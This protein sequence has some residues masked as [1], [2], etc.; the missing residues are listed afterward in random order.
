MTAFVFCIGLMCGFLARFAVSR[1][2]YEIEPVEANH[3]NLS[4]VLIYG[5]LF[6]LL[7]L[8]L[9][10]GMLFVK[11]AV[12]TFLLG[13]VSFVDLKHQIIPDK[14]WIISMISGLV[15]ALFGTQSLM[16]SLFGMLTGGGLLFI[17]ALAPGALGGGDIKLMFGIGAFLGPYKVLWAVFLAFALSAVVIVFLLLFKIKAPKDHIPFG[18]FLALGSFITFFI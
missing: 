11:G 15:C 3:R 7:F 14:L 8:K 9:G 10:W 16:S 4:T 1:L 12:M 6:V 13:I 17:L 18:P 5:I 2:S